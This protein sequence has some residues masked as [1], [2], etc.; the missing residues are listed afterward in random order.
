M[1][2]RLAKRL[3]SGR[4]R[5]TLTVVHSSAGRPGDR[6][7]GTSRRL[8]RRQ[9]VCQWRQMPGTGRLECHWQIE[10]IDAASPEEPDLVRSCVGSIAA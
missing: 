5:R 7:G 8:Q 2:T 10:R 4:R 3:E 9:L 1:V 6:L